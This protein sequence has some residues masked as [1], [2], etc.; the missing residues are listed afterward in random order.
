MRYLLMGLILLTVSCSQKENLNLTSDC[1]PVVVTQTN[2]VC[3][4]WS[5]KYNDV[6]YPS[7]NIPDEFKQEGLTVCADFNLYSDMRLCPCCGGTWANIKSMR[8][9]TR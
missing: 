6:T 9:F 8:R 5:I 3:S 2:T 7:N 4:L 1:L